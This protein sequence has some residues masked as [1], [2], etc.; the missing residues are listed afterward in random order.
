M[1][2]PIFFLAGRAIPGCV[3][4]VISANLAAQEVIGPAAWGA[5][6]GIATSYFYWMGAIPAMVFVGLFMMRLVCS[7]GTL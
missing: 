5:K 4:G 3:V 2:A 1:R 6:Y 7:P